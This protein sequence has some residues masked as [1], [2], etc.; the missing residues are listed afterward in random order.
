MNTRSS[1]LQAE[2]LRLAARAA[3]IGFWSWTEAGRFQWDDSLYSL[4]GLDPAEHVPSPETLLHYVHP[5]DRVLLEEGG[6][7][8][9]SGEALRPKDAFRY[10]GPDGVLRWFE[11]HRTRRPGTGEIV[12]LIQDVTESRQSLEALR[13][14]EER[15]DLAREAAQVGIWDWDLAT[16]RMVLCHRARAIFGFTPGQ[17]VGIDDI[18]AITHPDDELTALAQT[19]LA[20]DPAIREASTYEYRVI[21]P[22]GAVRHVV[23]HGKA[24]FE[25]RHGAMQAVRYAGTLRDVTGQWELEQARQESQ[26]RLTLAIEAGRMA[27]WEFSFTEG[28]TVAHSPELNRLLGFPDDAR[29]SIDE[30]SSRFYPGERQRLGDV[31]RGALARGERFIDCEFRCVLPDESIRWLLMRADI[32]LSPAGTPVR[33]VGVLMDISERK[34]AEEHI[35]LLMREVNHRSKNL[36][37]VVQSVASQTASRGTPQDFVQRFGER[38]QGL[39]ASHDLLVRNNWRGVE[40]AELIR[41]QL[42]HFHDL[43]G[44]RIT[45]E[46]P[47]VHLTAPAAQTLGMA[48]HELATN[49]GK[50]GSLSGNAGTLA[51]HWALA[52]QAGEGRLSIHWQESGGPKVETAGRKGF[53]TLLIT[54]VTRSSLQADITLDLAPHGVR[55]VLDAPAEPILQS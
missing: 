21:R 28:A 23:A 2:S 20:L 11:I 16:G 9:I 30:L 49:A 6:R 15:L 26:R 35:R 47:A 55:W 46:G 52:E 42:S 51:I 14:S 24:M 5:E 38:L 32:A 31:V 18:R 29:P 12:G 4:L 8:I 54:Q 50:Y 22:D 39:S 40:L 25:R 53:G 44:T 34:L 7:A 37:S 45:L 17:P 36:L 48:F 10:V 19:R 3:R 1:S 27:V 13:D 33:A 41:S 43:I